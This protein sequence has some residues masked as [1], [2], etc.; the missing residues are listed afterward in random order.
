MSDAPHS[1]VLAKLPRMQ[2]MPLSKSPSKILKNH[3]SPYQPLKNRICNFIIFYSVRS[4]FVLNFNLKSFENSNTSILT[5]VMNQGNFSPF[6]TLWLYIALWEERIEDKEW[7][8]QESVG[9]LFDSRVY[10]ITL[11]PQKQNILLK[12]YHW[13]QLT[14]LNTDTHISE[15]STLHLDFP[16]PSDKISQELT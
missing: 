6:L 8:H 14:F 16:K 11:I 4:T 13:C 3:W 2:S 5:H 12:R 7:N 9:N 1:L 10:L 15:F